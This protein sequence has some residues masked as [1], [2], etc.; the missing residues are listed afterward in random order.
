LNIEQYGSLD[1]F[2]WRYVGD[3]PIQ[4]TQPPV[5]AVPSEGMTSKLMSRDLRKRRL[6]FTSPVICYSFMQAVG[7]VKN[8]MDSGT[9][10]KTGFYF[11]T[12]HGGIMN[13]RIAS[14]LNLKHQP[15]ALLW[16]EEKTGKSSDSRG[17]GRA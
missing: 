14:I 4:N 9:E 1:A 10:C 5:E 6:D 7:M 3:K 13:R 2:I 11:S 16:A 8:Q 12:F 15:V 17:A